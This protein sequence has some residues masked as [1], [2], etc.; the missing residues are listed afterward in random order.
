[1]SRTPGRHGIVTSYVYPPI[2]VRDM[3]WMANVE[4]DEEGP[5]GRGETE[6]DALR[7]LAGQLALLWIEALPTN[8]DLDTVTADERFQA[9]CQRYAHGNGSSR[10]IASAA[11]RK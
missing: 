11:L 6:V 5:T 1:M 4:G 10:A 3:D 8:E 7:D 9:A 2:P